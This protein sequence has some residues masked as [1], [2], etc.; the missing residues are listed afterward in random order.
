M[1]TDTVESAYANAN[2]YSPGQESYATPIY[3]P[4]SGQIIPSQS[5]VNFPGSKMASYP[6]MTSNGLNNHPPA[7]TSSGGTFEIAI[8]NEYVPSS[9]YGV[10]SQN[11]YQSSKSGEYYQQPPA[12]TSSAMGQYHDTSFHSPA[13]QGINPAF[14]STSSEYNY[15]TAYGRAAWYQDNGSHLTRCAVDNGYC[16]VDVD[17]FLWFVLEL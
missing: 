1:L 7:S 9:S 3:P 6:R 4:T 17:G 16:T 8:S 5:Q 10:S 14:H 13:G 12:H 15:G 2:G 11:W